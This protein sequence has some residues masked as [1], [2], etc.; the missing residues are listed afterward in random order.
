MSLNESI[1]S[2]FIGY[3]TDSVRVHHRTPLQNDNNVHSY[4]LLPI[5]LLFVYL[6]A[7]T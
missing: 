4:F 5:D 7:W 3:G 2:G 1:L 6:K